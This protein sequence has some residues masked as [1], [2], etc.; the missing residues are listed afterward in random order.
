MKQSLRFIIAAFFLIFQYSSFA[1]V[2]VFSNTTV[3]ACDGWNSSNAWATALS[4]PV[5]VSGLPSGFVLREVRVR[6]GNSTCRGNLSTYSLRLTN[7]Q[8]GQVAIANNL[9]STGSSIWVD[10]KFRDDIALERLKEYPSVTVQASY[11]PHSIGFF[12]LETDGSFA[13]V[14]TGADPNGNWN[15]EIIENTTTEVSFEK[16]ELVFGPSIS[17]RDVTSCSSNNFCAGASC[18]YDGVFRG[19]NN[20]YPAADP[21]YPGNTVNGCSWNGQNNNSAW[22][23]FIPTATTARITISGMLNSTTPTSGDMQPI[24]VKANGNCGIPNI[25]PAGGCPKDQTRNNRAYSNDLAINPAPNTGGVSTNSIYSNGISSNCEFN[26]SGLIV[27]ETYYLYVDGN[28]GASSFF[29]IE[30]ENGVSTPCDFCCTPITIAGPASVCSGGAAVNFTRTGGS[31]SGTWT[32]TPASA[33]TIS[34]TGVFTPASG[35]TSDILAQ[36]NYT[37]G[38]CSRTADII[39]TKCTTF[40]IF[41]TAPWLTTCLSNS[42]FNST[43]TGEDLIDRTEKK[44]FNDTFLG[45]YVQ[46]SGRLKLRGAEVKTFKNLSLANVCGAKFFYRVVPSGGTSGAFTSIDLN[47]FNDCNTSISEFPSGGP[48]EA[49]DQKWQTVRSDAQSPVDLT[50]FAPG[51]Y[52]LQVYYEVTGDENSTTACDDKI[53]LDNAGRYYNATFTIQATPTLSSTNPTTCNGE[54]GT[55][56]LGG[57]APSTVYAVSYTD[58]GTLVGP[59]DLTSDAS[60]NIIFTGL[61]RG[62]YTSFSIAVNGCTTPVTGTLT[63]VNPVFTPTFPFAN[64]LSFCKSATSVP[65]LPGTSDNGLTG[66]WDPATVSNTANGTY[67]FTPNAGQC[68]INFVLNV[69]ITSLT[70][71]PS[72]TDNTVCNGSG[73]GSGACVSKGTG[74]VI[75]EVKHYPSGAQGIIANGREYIELYNPTCDPIDISC[76]IISTR[77][78][79]NSNPNSTLATGGSIILPQGTVIQPKA[80]FVIGTSAS[81]SNPASVDFK[82]DQ[83]AALYCNTGNFV[84]ANGDGW[85]GLYDKSGVPVD[86]IYWTVSAGQGNKISSD[87][88]LDDAPCTPSTVTGCSTSGVTL[89]SAAQIFASLPSRINYVGQALIGTGGPIPP[90]TDK[91]FSRVPDGGAWQRNVDPSIDGSNCNNG[92]CD[93]PTPSTGTCNG[94][95]TVSVS[96]GTGP[97]VYQWKDAQNTIVSNIQSASGLCPGD[98]CVIVTDSTSSCS[99]SVCVTILDA[100]T[101]V[102]PDFDPVASICAGSPAPLL[103]AK[104]KNNVTG[105]WS[106]ATVDNQNSGTYTF[107][108]DAGQ[109]AAT[110]TLTI[111]VN[112]KVEPLFDPVAGFCQG[113]ILPQVILPQTSNNGIIGTWNPPALS[114]AVAGDILYVFTPNAGVCADTASLTVKVTANITPSFSFG[115]TLTICSGANVPQLPT[116]SD[117][118]IT[119]SWSASVVDN[120][121]SGVYTFTPTSGQCATTATF[122]VTVNQ[123]VTPTFTYGT[124][125]TVCSGDPTPNLQAISTNNVVGL[126]NPTNVSNTQSDVYTFT[127][128]PGSCATTA[129]FTVTVIQRPSFNVRPDT[130]VYHNAIYPGDFF[131]VTPNGSAVSWTNSNTSIGL[132]SSGNGNIPAFTAINTGSQAVTATITVNSTNGNCSGTTRTFKITVLPLNRD[133][134]VPNVFTPNGDGRNDQLFVFGNYITKLEMRIFNQ[135]GEMIKVINNPATGWDG[136][137]KGKPQPVGVYVYTLRAT[138]ADGTEVNKKGSITLVR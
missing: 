63:L 28:G 79:P 128:A 15:F 72:K 138:L 104:S 101:N 137:H 95:A 16:V 10:M 26:L 24:V 30:V 51:T 4:R 68:A 116:T 77:S 105:T 110:A 21:Q 1:Q 106:P 35:I 94:T 43:G 39:V 120:T 38:D 2:Q 109:C 84:L 73:G 85:V 45:T 117:N 18:I 19:N 61:N 98:Y 123:P 6:L 33:G 17:V 48:C 8:G 66:S 20:G 25:V 121:Q 91:T 99:D 12:A 134:F 126:W 87:D 40:G 29:Y 74:V 96:G 46:N 88:D 57:L 102:T 44:D 13:N 111:T 83:N 97:Y 34:S 90:P 112:P 37:E 100:S 86:A 136:T 131:S 65:S 125:L 69:T 56:T 5:A 114:S 14:N 31:G 107:T 119:G 124:T 135:W 92:Q 27:G 47:F 55:I 49:G 62:V 70:L 59:T 9:S 22:F 78:A 108:P 81:S 64:S 32:V 7:P 71:T 23:S 42:F 36:V 103:P 82:T 54:E 75:N 113:A 53:T 67:T 58:D 127:P 133:V 76:Y 11:Y 118:G 60:G 132:P 115:T 122:T 89:L 3:A 52:T 80:H 41:A 50:A 130:T 129:T 93:T